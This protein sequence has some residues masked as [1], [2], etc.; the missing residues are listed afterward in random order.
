MT[1]KHNLYLL[2]NHAVCPVCHGLVIK[3]GG[4][5]FRCNDCEAKYR[6]VGCGLADKEIEVERIGGGRI[7]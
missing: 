5:T 1:E 6:I 7:E 2:G 4:D 3:A